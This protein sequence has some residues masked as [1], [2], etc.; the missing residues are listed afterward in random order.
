MR[1]PEIDLD[2]RR[3]QDLVNEA[4]LRIGQALPGVDRAQ[5][6][7]PGHHADRAVRVDDRDARLPPQPHP[8]QAPRRA[9]RAARDPSCDP[10]S[11]AATDLRFRLAAPPDGG[12]ASSPAARPRSATVRTAGEE[13]VVFQTDED[14]TIPADRAGRLRGRARRDGQG[15]RRRQRRRRAARAPT[16]SPFGTPPKVGDALYLGFDELARAACVRPGRR[17]LL[18]GARRRR[19]PEDP[20]LRWEVSRRATGGLGRGGG[21]RGP[22]RRLQL[23]Q[24]RRRAAARRH[25]SARRASPASAATGCAAAS[26]RGTRSGADRA[27][28]SRH[29]PE[30]YSITAAPIG[31]LRAGRALRASRRRV[32]RRERRHARARPSRCRYAPVL[33]PT[34]GETLEV[35]RARTTGEWEAWDARRVVRRERPRRPALRR[36]TLAT[37]RSSSARRSAAADGGWRQYGAV[38]PKGAPLRFTALPLRRRARAA[39]SPPAR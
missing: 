34:D 6:L 22:H 3:F 26:T 10:P 30:I 9:A 39:T 14:F 18:P 25:A 27:P 33:A 32:A 29:P 21:A 1:L 8:G 11:A 17:R 31:A 16:S 13:P 15:R 24:R 4:R 23:R 19:R 38:P 20:P 35:L 37:A 7:R 28:P 12:R 5:R 2:D 36:S